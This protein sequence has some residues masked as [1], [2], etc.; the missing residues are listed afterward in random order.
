MVATMP[1]S[2]FGIANEC[3]AYIVHCGTVRNSWPCDYRVSNWNCPKAIYILILYLILLFL[4]SFFF[5]LLLSWMKFVILI[6]VSKNKN[7][8][9]L[10]FA[11]DRN[12]AFAFWSYIFHCIEANGHGHGGLSIVFAI[13]H[14]SF[15]RSACQTGYAA[16]FFHYRRYTNFARSFVWVLCVCAVV[17]WVRCVAYVCEFISKNTRN[18][19]E[20]N[21]QTFAQFRFDYSKEEFIITAE[22][23][24]P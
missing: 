2:T 10:W 8:V 22:H 16:I 11:T 5:L 12:S 21:T 13:N 1:T 18:H 7:C 23:R 4:F 17:W 9:A 20:Q 15:G 3:C 6:P 24:L 14:I 19:P